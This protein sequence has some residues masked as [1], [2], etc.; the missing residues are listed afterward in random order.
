MRIFA[1]TLLALMFVPTRLVAQ[2][3]LDNWHFG[4]KCGISFANGQPIAHK[5][6]DMKAIFG[7][8]SMSDQDGN[9][10]FYTNGKSVWNYNDQIMENGDDINA[11]A[12]LI[13]GSSRVLIIPLPYSKSIYY[14]YSINRNSDSLYYAIIE[15]DANDGR[16]KVISKQKAVT[17]VFSTHLAAV[18]A[19]KMYWLIVSNP[20]GDG[21]SSFRFDKNGIDFV[22]IKSSFDLGILSTGGAIASN[23]GGSQIAL[24][25]VNGFGLMDFNL[26]SGVAKDLIIVDSQYYYNGYTKKI[27]VGAYGVAFSPNNKFLYTTVFD[28]NRVSDLTSGLYQYELTSLNKAS[29]RQSE[30]VLDQRDY[31]GYADIK[32]KGDS[33]YLNVQSSDFLGLIKNPNQQ[34]LDCQFI[35]NGV[36]LNGRQA[37]FHLPSALP[38]LPLPDWTRS[39][40][41]TEGN[42]EYENIQ[43]SLFNSQIVDSVVIHFGDGIMQT[44]IPPDTVFN[45]IYT[46]SSTYQLKIIL[47]YNGYTDSLMST[48]KVEGVAPL[49]LGSDTLLCEGQI[50]PLLLSLEIDSFQWSDLHT[51]LNRNISRQGKYVLSVYHQCANQIDSISVNYEN[52]INTLFIPNA[53]SPNNNSLND[54]FKPTG[55]GINYVKMEIYNRWGELIFRNEGAD[56]YWS[57]A[58]VPDG[59]Y[60][61]KLI[62]ELE[63]KGLKRSEVRAGTVHVLR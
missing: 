1:I 58:D 31:W 61:Y 53:F 20:N 29:I 34:G 39:Y 33:T 60:V 5:N 28:N 56:P 59:V 13:T 57:A 62:V 21:L 19:E 51:T 7:C 18:Q 6:S 43:I 24:T 26:S 42:C 30:V 11:K 32:T 47:H 8:S 2:R 16:G 49:D 10:L 63:Y 27:Y 12:S 35:F 37:G 50:L 48:L 40:V 3:E 46:K 9:L 54:V 22:P 15:M 14:I 41:L 52:C 4:D 36:F 44:F 55:I 38:A 17:K 23:T 45:H 25:T